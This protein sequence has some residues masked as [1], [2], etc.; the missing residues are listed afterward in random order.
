MLRMAA[1]LAAA[2][3]VSGLD[4][5]LYGIDYDTRTS[6]WGGCKSDDAIRN[7]FRVLKTITSSVRIYTLTDGCADRLLNVASEVDM[8]IWLGIWGNVNATQDA[9]EPEFKTLQRLVLARRVR[10]DNVVGI[11]VASEALFRYYSQEKHDWAEEY[12][13]VQ[14]LFGYVDKV[15]SF[16][17]AQ[18]LA[19]PVTIADVMDSYNSVPE[20]YN[21]VDVV[22]VNQFSQWEGVLATDGVNVLFERMVD[23]QLAARKAGKVVVISETGWS[24]NGTVA[25]IKEAT[26]ESSATFLHDFMR[27]TEQQN[28]AYYYFT[29]FNLAWDGN[30]DF[31]EIEQ[32]FG[33]FDEHRNL[34]P[35]VKNVTL[36][37][38]HKPVRLWHQGRVVKADGP[39]TKTFGRVYLDVPAR[40]LSDSLDREI[41]F[42]DPDVGSFRSRSTNQCLVANQT[43]NTLH[44]TWCHPMTHAAQRW[45]FQS[46]T[47]TTSPPTTTTTT[48][49]PRPTTTTAAPAA[50]NPNCGE[51]D[52]CQYSTPYYSL[53]YANWSPID[54]GRMGSTHHWCGPVDGRRLTSKDTDI[55]VMKHQVAGRHRSLLSADT[56]HDDFV[57]ML[58]WEGVSN[59]DDVPL[60][61]R[62][63]TDE[64]GVD[65]APC[66]SSAGGFSF[67]VRPLDA[68]EI[69]VQSLDSGLLLT[70]T[71]NVLGV[72]VAAP[73]TDKAVHD[74]NQVWYYD[75]LFQRIRSN[76]YT[77]YDTCLDIVADGQVQARGC[78][79]SP[80]QAWSYNDLTGQV[81]SMGKLGRCLVTGTGTAD[82][83]IDFCDVSN[84]RQKWAFN[85][86][87][88]A[89]PDVDFTHLPPI[90]TTTDAP[91]TTVEPTTSTVAPT[92]TIATT[93]PPTATAATTTTPAP[94][95]T[96]QEPPVREFVFVSHSK[97][98]VIARRPPATTSTGAPARV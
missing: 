51:C 20:I 80:S 65:V 31:G 68:E 14:K 90:P 88:T 41:W 79:H 42:Y 95:T 50:I 61:M 85:L 81:L 15:R 78:D 67:A 82:A 45:R 66:D 40:G 11:H 36:G 27:Y 9:F 32:N 63:K 18:N 12:S 43:E 34:L 94:S 8:R 97:H 58:A 23:I 1:V 87:T 17:R 74:A 26:P 16:L 10:N 57:G 89:V 22:S 69:T 28:I 39:N 47:P 21:I 71:P 93:V 55:A 30:S 91:T 70:A 92:T 96:T 64:F 77:S 76:A 46:S 86:V 19:F 24:A 44:V 59:A 35:H 62:A 83:A 25:A 60:C 5:P 33:L 56:T 2:H 98:R 37:A 49:T 38:Y 52:N 29:S 3:A 73:A 84:P 13:G 48:I 53:C 54:C 7:D 4:R 75:P 6:E 72:T